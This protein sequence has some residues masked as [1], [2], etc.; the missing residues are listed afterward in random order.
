[1]RKLFIITSLFLTQAIIGQKPMVLSEYLNKESLRDYQIYFYHDPD[2]QFEISTVYSPYY[3]DKFQRFDLSNEELGLNEENIE[4]GDCLWFR[5]IFDNRSLDKITYHLQPGL[6]NIVGEYILY[7]RLPNGLIT[8]RKSGFNLDPSEKDVNISGSDDMRFYVTP[9]RH[10]TVYLYSKIIEETSIPEIT[11]TVS[12]HD[13][14]IRKDKLRRLTFGF[15]LGIMSI[16]ILYNL[17]IF[18]QVRE[19]SYLYYILYIIAFIAFFVNKE[20]YIYEL[21]HQFTAAPINVFLLQLFLL[22]YLLLGRA[23]LD[24]RKNLRVWDRILLIGIGFISVGLVL[25]L[26]LLTLSSNGIRVPDLMTILLMSF[27]IISG[28]ASLSLMIMPAFILR[29]KK[30]APATYFLIA[31]LFL[32]IG[33][34][35]SLKFYEVPVV[36]KHWLELGV[37]LQIATF[38]VGLGNK[39]N[40]LKRDREIAQQRII[41][42]LREN[43]ALKDKV[44]RELED[45]VRERTR[46]IRLQK[47]QIERQNKEIKYSFDY[48]KRIQSTV[49]PPFDVFENL[50]AEHFILLKPRDIVSGDFYWISQKENKVFIT[51]S[52]CTGHGVP[53]SLM[54]MLGITML[55][56]IVNEKDFNRS[57]EILNEL[58]ISIAR[59][60]KQEGKPGEQKDGMDMVMLIYDRAT[61]K[62]EFSGAN[63]PMYIIRNKKMIEYKGNNMPVAYYDNMTNF[64]RHTIKLEKGDRVYLFTDGFPDQFGGP[65]GKKFKYKPFK[66]LLLEVHE[67][68]MEEQRR[69]LQMVFD[70]WKGNLDQIDD[71]LVMGLRF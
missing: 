19:I 24:T 41:M 68:P 23:Y 7:Q 11:F 53:G 47:E 45:K 36:G 17:T 35:L 22:C 2:C 71:V 56:E 52:D 32:I 1:M 33:L 3:S 4:A 43:T 6:F 61:R 50:F 42:Q 28:I 37:T 15:F 69:I 18:L 70:E 20:G 54:S 66:E 46:E 62:L 65:N 21:L 67:R 8:Q 48:A 64:T 44:N 51:A 29:K 10:D 57:D 55:H 27:N 49:L 38:S 16:M 39:I 12:S 63:N 26:V 60:L 31:N 59:T 9:G 30:F 13:N 40:L 5:F 14:V 34:I 58:R 25:H